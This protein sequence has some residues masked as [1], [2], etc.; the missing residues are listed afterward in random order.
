V[1]GF[2]VCRW[3]GSLGGA[4]SRWLSSALLFVPAFPLDRNHSA[5]KIL[6]WVGGSIPQPAALPIHG[7]GLFSFYLSFVG[8]F[9]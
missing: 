8:Y 6:R 9:S 2:D 4:V 3:D 5:L 7:Y 1:S